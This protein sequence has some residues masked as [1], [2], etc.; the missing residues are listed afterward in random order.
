MSEDSIEVKDLDWQYC[1]DAD[2]DTKREL[3]GGVE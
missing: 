2:K 1:S 3:E